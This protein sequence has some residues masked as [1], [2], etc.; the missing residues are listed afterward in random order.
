VRARARLTVSAVIANARGELVCRTRD[1]SDTGLF[2]ET[3]VVL[4]PQ[5]LL[6]LSLLDQE[7]GEALELEGEVARVVPAEQAGGAGGLGVRLRTPPDAW[8]ALVQRFVQN[9]RVSGMHRTAR[10]LRVLVVG[11]EQRRRGALALYVTSGW[12]VRFASDEGSTKEALSGFGIDVVI[13]EHDLDDDRWP[14]ILGAARA[15]QPS[16]KRIIRAHL[17]PGTPPPAPGQAADLVHRV[18][19][20]HA[21]LEAV[22]E[23]VAE[24]G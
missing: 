18:V 12:D 22:L 24:E 3:P 9:P 17:P 6:S 15:A 16:A 2:L 10:R 20:V 19:D 21:G 7:R 1:V 23:A 5:T 14:T 8:R 11:D 13:A 4:E